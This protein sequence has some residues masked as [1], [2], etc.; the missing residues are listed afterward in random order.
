[1]ST[2][3]TRFDQVLGGLPRGCMTIL[4]AC[5]SVGKTSLALQWALT[6]AANEAPALF[7]TIEMTKERIGKR[8]VTYT[9]GQSGRDI[10]EYG[11]SDSLRIVR[12]RV[13]PDRMYVTDCTRKIERIVALSR[14]Y[15]REH[16]VKLI[17]VDYLQLCRTEGKFHSTND[18]VTEMSR[19][20]KQLAT[21]TGV[22]LVV[23]SQFNREVARAKRAPMLSDLRDS[24][25]IEN[26][27]D[28]VVFLSRDESHGV[29]DDDPECKIL[30][31]VSKNR[32]GETFHGALVFEKARMRFRQEAVAANAY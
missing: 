7:F 4:A 32:D 10:G 22:A 12:Q 16:D 6:A 23:L 31:Q 25:S 1:M 27:A 13:L 30:L 20:L 29:R 11:L 24:G 19:T 9:T 15:V 2:G 18:L 3:M 21:D 8:I 17:V 28:V 14:M 5:T 26:D